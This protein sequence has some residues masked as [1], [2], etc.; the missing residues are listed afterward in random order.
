M[1]KSECIAT[2]TPSSTKYPMGHIEVALS[3]P[4]LTLNIQKQMDYYDF[5]IWII[6]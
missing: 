1:V 6:V 4:K 2:R 5:H 3:F